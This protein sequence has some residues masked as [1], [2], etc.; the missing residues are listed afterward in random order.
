MEA[1]LAGLPASR[2]LEQWVIKGGMHAAEPSG[3]ASGS[4]KTGFAAREVRANGIVGA[5][6]GGVEIVVADVE[7]PGARG[8]GA[9]GSGVDLVGVFEAGRGKVAWDRAPRGRGCEWVVEGVGMAWLGWS[10]F[11]ERW[12]GAELA[13][14]RSG[15]L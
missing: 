6:A 9:S 4:G 15:L 5:E 13:W 8:N 3:S 1:V 14:S 12:A 2:A 7:G 11:L 10:G